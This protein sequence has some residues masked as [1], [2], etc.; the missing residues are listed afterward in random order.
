M[1]YCHM[2]DIGEIKITD[3]GARIYDLDGEPVATFPVEMSRAQARLL[4]QMLN[5]AYDMGVKHGAREQLHEL[6]RA[7]ELARYGRGR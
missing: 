3:H 4:V 2:D 1:T 6:A 7:M 5:R